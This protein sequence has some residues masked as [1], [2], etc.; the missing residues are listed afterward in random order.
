MNDQF[1]NEEEVLMAGFSK[2]E[3]S[4]ATEMY[5]TDFDK[6]F[7]AGYLTRREQEDYLHRARIFASHRT[8]SVD[9]TE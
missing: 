5:E 3:L 6:Y 1:R 8:K 4:D 2:E 7:L 9:Q